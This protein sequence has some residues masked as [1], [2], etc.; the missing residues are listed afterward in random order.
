MKTKKLIKALREDAALW[1][2]GEW[3]CNA[4][5]P[6]MAADRLEMLSVM[7]KKVYAKLKE[8]REEN[9]T[10]AAALKKEYGCG[11]CKHCDC[12][13]DQEPCD[14]CRQDGNFPKW[15]WKGENHG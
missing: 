2:K 11:G 8:A 1:R 9:A 3:P 7:S 13:W 10:M 4:V 6:D 14:S 12:E 5:L 15:V